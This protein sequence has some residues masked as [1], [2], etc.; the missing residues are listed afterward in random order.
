MKK[1]KFTMKGQN[2]L[3]MKNRIIKDFYIGQDVEIVD[4]NDYDILV[5]CNSVTEEPKVSREN[6]IGVIM[7]PS[8]SMNWDRNLD[9][10]CGTIFVHDN[11]LFQFNDPNCNIIER[12]SLMFNE[13]YNS[14]EYSVK[15]YFKFHVPK[16]KKISFVVSKNGGSNGNIIYD[17]RLELVEAIIKND[18]PIDIYGR[19]WQSNGKQIKGICPDD[20]KINAL[21]EYQFS[22]G[23][24]NSKEKNYISEK[25]FDNLLVNTVPIYYGCPNIEDVYNKNSFIHLDIDNIDKTLQMLENILNLKYYDYIDLIYESKLIYINNHNLITEILKII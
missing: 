18:L 25:F 4:D 22:I 8:W 19:G 6:I 3:F 20:K 5:Y 17:K 23:I 24:E 12:P 14:F 15:D 16:T 7:E 2:N 13:F 11:S 10:F 9:K 21:M 1:I